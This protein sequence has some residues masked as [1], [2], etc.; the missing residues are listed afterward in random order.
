MLPTIERPLHAEYNPYYMGYIQRVPEGNIFDILS[1]QLTELKELLSSVSTEQANFR[2]RAEEWNLKQ[3]VGHLSDGERI[4]FYRA[5][6]ISRQDATPLAS[7]DQDAYVNAANFNHC[8]L[9]DLVDEFQQ[10]RLANLASL[11]LLS[12]DAALHLGHVNGAAMSVRALVYIMV[13]H[14]DYHLADIRA[15]Y[16]VG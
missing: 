16:L 15:Q 7:F 4:F 10:I 3:I 11:K 2:P 6:C 12:S 14:V 13:G 9:A 5:L 1:N 8:A